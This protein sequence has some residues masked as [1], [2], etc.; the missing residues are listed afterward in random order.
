MDELIRKSA[1]EVVAL[2]KSGAVSP[3]E[4][5]DA[6]AA[7]IEATDSAVNALPT[8]CLDRARDRAKAIMQQP[9]EDEPGQLYG[10]P[11]PI[12]DLNEV[13]GVRTTFGSPIYADH[14]SPHSDYAVEHLESRG[15]VVIGKSNT[16]EFGAG[17]QTFNEVFGP[18]RN[19]WNTALTPGGS[20]GGAAAALAAG[21]AWL[22]SGSDL[23]GSLR[24]PASFCSVVGLRPSPGRVA[25]GPGPL[26][27]QSLAVDGPM[28]RSV[29]DVALMLDAM[30]GRDRRD[31]LSMTEPATPFVASVDA[32]KSPVRVAFS[33]DL[34]ITPVTPEVADICRQAA[35]KFQELGAVVEEACPDFSEAAECFHLLRAAL[36]VGTKGDLL[37]D[38]RDALKPEVIWNIEAGLALTAEDVIR[39]ERQ[40][41]VI[42]QR[43]VAFFEKYDLLLC[44]AAV[45][46]PFD[47]EIR[48]PNRVNGVALPNYTDWL[49]I[50]GAITLTSCPAISVP[51]GIT[52]DGRPVGLQMVGRHH[53][54]A[55]LLSAAAAFEATTGLANQ[56]PIDPKPAKPVND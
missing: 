21:Q 13:E 26:P 51:C 23:G 52:A 53:G 19:P 3:L 6:A 46:P 47:C 48:W 8:L 5:I 24:N 40:R 16:P 18:T 56:V 1:R 54:E 50:C 27:F 43:S 41:A 33:P 17:S 2:L 31:P 15:G 9:A 28:G 35:V 36:F 10:L 44:P 49:L 38:H 4:L 32:P 55:A 37:P 34:G 7:R 22:A 45:V 30:A 20:S 25:H 42:F 14:V 29:G 11:L 12:K 39:G